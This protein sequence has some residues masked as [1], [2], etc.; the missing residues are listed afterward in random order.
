M[1]VPNRAGRMQIVLAHVL[2]V[3]A[4][5]LASAHAESPALLVPPPPAPT[6]QYVRDL[7]VIDAAAALQAEADKA[8]ANPASPAGLLPRS[9]GLSSVAQNSAAPTDDEE[10]FAPSRH[11]A[12]RL[13]AIFGVGSRLSALLNDNGHEV[14]Y[15]AG[16]AA[17]VSGP[18]SGI[19]LVKIAAPCVEM[20]LGDGQSATRCLNE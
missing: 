6:T 18:D 14:V 7:L 20:L 1:C 11:D 16:R 9:H 5:P 2:C 10:A 13:A 17:P 15:R 12:I 4:V 3:L 8:G 19:R